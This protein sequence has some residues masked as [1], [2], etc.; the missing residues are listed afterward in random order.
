MPQGILTN[1]A[2]ADWNRLEAKQ[3][4]ITRLIKNIVCSDIFLHVPVNLVNVQNILHK[5]LR[6]FLVQRKLLRKPAHFFYHSGFYIFSGFAPESL[7]IQLLE[8]NVLLA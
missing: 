6:L 7:Q 4:R 2:E 1:R 8:V 3:L 5:L